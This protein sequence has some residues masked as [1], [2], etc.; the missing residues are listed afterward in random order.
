MEKNY[1]EDYRVGEVFVSPGRTIT[2]TDIVLFSA[3]TGD[4]HELHTN[5]EYAA[6]TP[7]KGRIA[8]GMLGLVTGMALLFRLGPYVMLPRSFIAFYGMDGVRFTAPVRIG[9]T[10]HCE[11]QVTALS[12]KDAKRGIIEAKSAIKNQ[13]GETAIVLTTKIIVGRK[14]L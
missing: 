9:D 3:F 6:E 7:F 5:V 8:H 12:E 11:M 13:K 10:I 14:P 1:F 2:E 4:W